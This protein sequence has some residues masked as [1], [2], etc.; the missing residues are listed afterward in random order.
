M[1]YV[2]ANTIKHT[3]VET[4]SGSISLS[5]YLNFTL[6]FRVFKMKILKGQLLMHACVCLYIYMQKTSSVHAF[7]KVTI[8]G[9]FNTELL[10]IRYIRLMHTG[11]KVQLMHYKKIMF[12]NKF[13][14]HHYA[15][16][17]L[18]LNIFSYMRTISFKSI[19]ASICQLSN[20][21]LVSI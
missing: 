9:S 16:K 6:L 19:S 17:T 12:A 21:N 5:H 20:S 18:P 7:I 11:S 1:G 2:K 10:L 14:F 8:I 13:K 15:I 4:Q 3:E